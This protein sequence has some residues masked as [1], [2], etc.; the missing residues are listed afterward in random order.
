[1]FGEM[2]RLPG[3]LDPNMPLDHSL[4]DI[5]ERAKKNAARP[6][7]QTSL[8]KELPVFYPPAAQNATHVYLHRGKKTPLSPIAD[9]PYLIKERLGKSCLRISTGDFVNGRPRTEVVHWKNCSPHIIPDSP[10]A[11]PDASKPKLGRPAHVAA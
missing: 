11:I 9:G 7:A 1:M 10:D 3:D 4:A 8:R 2:P 6:P 5:L